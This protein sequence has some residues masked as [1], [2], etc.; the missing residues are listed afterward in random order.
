MVNKLIIPIYHIEEAEISLGTI[1]V[2]FFYRRNDE[3]KI[4]YLT[5]FCRK[6]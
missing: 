2:Q 3:K 6:S 5:L 4:I 1:V